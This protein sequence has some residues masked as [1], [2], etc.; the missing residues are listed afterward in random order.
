MQNVAEIARPLHKASEVTA[1]F[2]WTPE[3]HDAFETLKSGLTTTPIL[4]FPMMKEP[5]ILYTDANRTAMGAVLSQVQDGQERAICYASKAFSKTQTRYS[6]TKRELL[7]V[8]NFTRH[9]KHY[10]LGHKFTII[11]DHRALKWLHNFKDPDALTARWLEKSAA[12]DYEVVHRPRKSIG[13]ADGLSRTPFR[14]FNASATED[15]AANAPEDDQEWPNRT[16]ESPLDPKQFQYSEVQV[17]VLQSTDSIAHCTS[18]DFK[19]GA[20]I[21]RSIKRRFPTQY[22]DKEAIAREVIWPQWIPEL[23]RF[24]YHLITKVRY[25]HKPT[26]KTLRLSLEAMKNHAESNNILRISMP[27][28]G[29]GLDKLDWIKV[30][31]LIQEVFRSTNIEVIVFLK[32]SKGPPRASQNSVDS[33]D[34]VVA[35]ETPNNSQTLI[36]LASAQKAD[37]A[38]KNL[39]QWVTRGTPPSTHKLQGLPRATWQLVNEFRSLKIINDVLCREFVHKGRPSYFQ[40]LIPASLVPQ[41]LN[42]IHSSTFGGHLGIFKTVEEVR[43]RFYWPGFLEDVNLFIIRCEQCQK[44]AKQPK[45]HRHSLIE[46]TPSYP[47]HHIGIV[48]MGPLPLPNGNQHILLIGD[49]FSKCYEALPLPDQTA[50]TTATALL[51]NWICRFG[52]PHIIHSD[53]GRNFESKLFK[54]MNQALQVDKTRTTALRPQSNAVVE[55]MNRTLQSMLAKCINDEQSN[56]SQQLPYVMMAYRTSVH[57]STGYTPHFLVYGQEVCLPIDFIYP[58]PSDQPPNDTQEFVS[59]RQVRFQK[60]YDSART[61]LN[62]N[63]PRRNALYNRRSMDR[64]IKSIKTF[65]YIT[66]SSQWENHQ[67]SLVHGKVPMSFYKALMMLPTAFKKLQLKRNSLFIMTDSSYSM[68]TRRPRMY[69]RVIKQI[70]KTYLNQKLSNKNHQ[71]PSTTTINAPGIIRTIPSHQQQLVLVALL[72]QPRLL[73]LH[74]HLY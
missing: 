29:C 52:C 24:V 72:A 49:H 41:V 60:A 35:A 26:Y 68:N 4:A 8:V 42:S 59:A 40:Q 33:F 13:H 12:F 22:P 57:E 18:V 70:R 65:C 56:W 44:R 2:N 45:T 71:F 15:P 6:A 14:A 27:Q 3:A 67:S 16:N 64:P 55:R 69:Q 32:P 5:F 11:T 58:N 43:E 48:F 1:I 25:F 20:G 51:E 9:F 61:A 54:S 19:L 47:F 7:A 73:R 74:Q 17:D 36:F 23:Q 53:Q 28:I 39:F 63:Q 10:L 46:W 37:P 50:S 38:L 31:T 30:R 66:P 62:F 34:D 21:A